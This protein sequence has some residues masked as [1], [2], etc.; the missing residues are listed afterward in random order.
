MLRLAYGRISF[1]FTGDAEHAA[2]YEMLATVRDQLSATVLKVAHHGSYTSSSPEFLAAVQPA[3]AIYSAGRDNTYGHPHPG[4]I[5]ALRRIG[6][7]VYGTDE[8]GTIVI[9]T[10]GKNYHVQTEYDRPPIQAPPTDTWH[11]SISLIPGS[12][13]SIADRDCSDFTTQAEAQAFFLANGGPGRDP[14]R[15]DGDNDGIAC[16]RLP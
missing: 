1:L 14:H 4:T 3:V 16:E 2:E 8:H 6:A 15:L 10:D 12:N 7:T 5:Q 11:D 13:L 9:T